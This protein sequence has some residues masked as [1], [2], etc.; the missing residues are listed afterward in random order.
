MIEPYPEVGVNEMRK[1]A[2]SCPAA[3]VPSS[4]PTAVLTLPCGMDSC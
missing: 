2:L 4:K 1:N 3:M